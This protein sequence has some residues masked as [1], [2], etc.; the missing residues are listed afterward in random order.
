MSSASTET[1]SSSITS[2]SKVIRTPDTWITKA[3]VIEISDA[4]LLA[5]IA[6]L[7][8]LFAAMIGDA[9][10]NLALTILDIMVRQA[11]RGYPT[12]LLKVEGQITAVMQMDGGHSESAF[13]VKN[14]VTTGNYPGSGALMIEQAFELCKGRSKDHQ[15]SLNS[16]NA[17]STAA[18]RAMGFVMDNGS[19][20]D[21]SGDMTLDPAESKKWMLVKKHYKYRSLDAA[22]S[23]AAAKSSCCII[24]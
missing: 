1:I 3:P 4:Q 10:A 7:R 19:L 6:E 21:T 18:Y 9:R 23:D 5:A 2:A 13:E 15:I 17:L 22:R 14:L 16:H 24:C 11:G 8:T 20:T 12:Y